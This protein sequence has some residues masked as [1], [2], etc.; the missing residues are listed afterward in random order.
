VLKNA[1]SWT[2]SATVRVLVETM[3]VYRLYKTLNNSIES[4]DRN[5]DHE[6][7]NWMF[8]YTHTLCEWY[9][10]NCSR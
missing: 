7:P 9:S 5:V 3:T 6:N 4:S 10:I 2:I 1:K 8:S